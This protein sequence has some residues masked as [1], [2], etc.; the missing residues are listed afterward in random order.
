MKISL[1]VRNPNSR[2][3]YFPVSQYTCLVPLLPNTCNLYFFLRIGNQDTNFTVS[4]NSEQTWLRN[5]TCIHTSPDQ[6]FLSYCQTVLHWDVSVWG[7]D[8][9]GWGVTT[10]RPSRNMFQP[11]FHPLSL[12]IHMSLVQ[13]LHIY[14][15]ESRET[16]II[17]R[18]YGNWKSLHE[19]MWKIISKT[20]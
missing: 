11:E 16:W 14:L 17:L 8:L 15:T 1:W 5:V 13:E 10:G 9:R 20:S 2:L 7:R 3:S 18:H 19:P 6:S 4:C 12:T